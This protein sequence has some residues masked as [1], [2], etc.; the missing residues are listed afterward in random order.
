D[1]GIVFAASSAQ[2]ADALRARLV[3]IARRVN[4]ALDRAGYRLCPGNIMAGNPE[5]CLSLD[6]WR[7]RFA[8]WNASG[9]P[10]ALR[11]GAIFF[12]LR[13]LTGATGLARDLRQWLLAEAPKNRRFLHQMTVNALHNRPALG[14]LHR[15]A[16]DADGAIDLKRNA[17]AP[18]IDAARILSLAGGIDE[19]RT[20]ARLAGAGR[21]LGI[22]ANEVE[23]WIA[24]FH[25]VQQYRLRRQVR[26]LQIGAAPDNRLRPGALHDFDRDVLRSALV[27]ARSLQRRLGLDYGVLT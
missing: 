9:R 6:E 21:A 14:F 19:V 7:A 16:T 3:P 11:A 18:F 17:A 24:A 20:G 8:G 5:W 10:R 22:P 27:Q 23:A 25:Q 1:N 2:E 13:P 26:C 4:E 15:F 12:D